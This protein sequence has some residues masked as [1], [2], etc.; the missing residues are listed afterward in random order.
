MQSD[1]MRS[2]IENIS[3]FRIDNRQSADRENGH[4]TRSVLEDKE[5][6][7]ATAYLAG[8]HVRQDRR[9]AFVKF[10][11]AAKRGDVEAALI[12]GYLY[13]NGIGTSMNCHEAR[14]WLCMAGDGGIEE[15]K[16]AM[17]TRCSSTGAYISR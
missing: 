5:F 10:L 14:H 3:E 6:D 7:E 2:D 8:R 12:V 16:F 17:R 15:V 11:E 1:V 13:A 9:R 4:R